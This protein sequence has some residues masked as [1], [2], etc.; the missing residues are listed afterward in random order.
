M[1]RTAWIAAVLVALI[2]GH[3][4]PAGWV[5]FQLGERRLAET[6]A[7]SLENPSPFETMSKDRWIAESDHAYA[8]RDCAQ[9]AP[10]HALVVPKERYATFLETPEPVLADMMGLVKKVARREGVAKSGFRVTMNTNPEAWQTVYHTHMHV[11]G[12]EQLDIPIY[13][14]AWVQLS[15][16]C[17]S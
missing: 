14:Y 5:L 11:L 2:A 9:L 1:K 3:F 13:R 4:D 6:K 8:I 7:R 17:P 16:Q 15:G 12:G 10:T